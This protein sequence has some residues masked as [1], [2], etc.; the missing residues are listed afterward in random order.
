MVAVEQQRFE[1]D[2]LVGIGDR[3]DVDHRIGPFRQG[4]EL[5]HRA[6]VV[7]QRLDGAVQ[8]T[9][10]LDLD[11]HLLDRHAEMLG[12]QPVAEAAYGVRHLRP[13]A[14]LDRHVGLGVEAQRTVAE[15][16]AADAQHSIVDDHELG[17]DVEAAAFA[18]RGN[19][20]VIDAEAAVPVGLAQPLDQARAQD[21]HGVLFQPAVRE[22]AQQ[23][24]DLRPVGLRQPLLQRRGDA[25]RGEVLVLDVERVLRRRDHVE[26]ELLDLLDRRQLAARRCGARDAD[27]DVL[28]L[29]REGGRP[30]IIVGAGAH[31]CDH[32]LHLLPGGGEPALA[33]QRREAARRFAVQHDHQVVERR[34]GLAVGD[35]PRVL[36]QV[37]R[38]VPAPHREVDAADE[39][40]SVVDHHDLLVMR[41]GHRVR[42]VVAQMHAPRGRRVI[43]VEHVHLQRV[44]PRDEV[45]QELAQQRRRPVRLNRVEVQARLA[46]EVPAED[47]DRVARTQRRFVEG[48]EV[49]GGVDD[50]GDAVGP[51]HGPAVV[52]RP[53]QRRRLRIA[54]LGG[55]R[56]AAVAAPAHAAIEIEDASHA[57]SAR[58]ILACEPGRRAWPMRDLERVHRSPRLYR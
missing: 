13:A 48:P 44:P 28:Q 6:S 18:Q 32:R 31:A 41:A 40:D 8:A 58:R 14:R 5:A 43:P 34:I 1:R 27:L 23:Q 24:H 55:R 49:V 30:R 3:S 25:R 57:S 22:Q 53:Q 42:V 54:M 7:H 29:R 12:E 39:G 33:R 50:Q 38:A 46:V 51:R 52:A 47:G 19:V 9:G 37:L 11:P 36:R 16:R 17:M 45:V 21:V 35:A 56:R 26:V 2:R 10:A 4:V 15:I 20:R